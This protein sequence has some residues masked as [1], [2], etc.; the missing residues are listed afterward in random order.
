MSKYKIVYVDE[1]EQ[2]YQEICK[3]KAF[4]TVKF[5]DQKS[6]DELLRL[7][8]NKGEK[9][10][11]AQLIV[12]EIFLL[13]KEEET[14]I[15]QIAS[16]LAKKKDPRGY[17]LLGKCFYYGIEVEKNNK[18]AIHQFKIAANLGDAFASYNLW[19]LSTQGVI[20]KNDG[21]DYLFDAAILD[22]PF[23]QMAL[24]EDFLAERNYERAIHW[25]NEALSNN[26]KDAAMY[27]VITNLNQLEIF[28]I[29][30]ESSFFRLIDP[31]ESRDREAQFQLGLAFLYGDL[32]KQNLGYAFHWLFEAGK[33]GHRIALDYVVNYYP[34]SSISEYVYD[35]GY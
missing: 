2:F 19:Y 35:N 14:R 26:E 8:L 16:E 10:L 4:K 17:N 29:D 32:T 18:T 15:Y 27:L 20:G 21:I 22:E 25:F 34:D 13:K 6:F 31:A 1:V 7:A 3:G 23:S 9:D 11:N 30:V 24:A 5:N 12:A 33:N 28:P